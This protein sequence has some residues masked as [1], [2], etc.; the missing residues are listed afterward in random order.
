MRG[1]GI[2]RYVCDDMVRIVGLLDYGIWRGG[3]DSWGRWVARVGLYAMRIALLFA[4]PRWVG[5]LF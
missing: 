5:F 1:V 3:R 2:V 4:R